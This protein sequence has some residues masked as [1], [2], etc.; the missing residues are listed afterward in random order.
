MIFTTIIIINNRMMP[1]IQIIVVFWRERIN[2]ELAKE[3]RKVIGRWVIGFVIRIKIEF[4]TK[5]KYIKVKDTGWFGWV[6]RK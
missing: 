3:E 4:K 1:N 5:E 2:V 6:A